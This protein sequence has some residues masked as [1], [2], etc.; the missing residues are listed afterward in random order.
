MCAC[1]RVCVCVCDY[2]CMCMYVCIISVSFVCDC[3]TV[4]AYACVWVFVCFFVCGS[5]CVFIIQKSLFTISS[6][7][8]IPHLSGD[9]PQGSIA[10]IFPIVVVV[11]DR[12]NRPK[13]AIFIRWNPEIVFSNL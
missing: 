5:V 4:C 8:L 2:L 1:V 13:H 12:N 11:C 9:A 3:I 10:P 7:F 6:S